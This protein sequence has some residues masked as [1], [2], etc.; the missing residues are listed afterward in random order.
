SVQLQAAA[1]AD[2]VAG[3]QVAGDTNPRFQIDSNGKM[4]W[5]T[6]TA[7][8][9]T[10]LSRTTPGSLTMNSLR[11]SNFGSAGNILNV[12]NTDSTSP[13]APNVQFIGHNAGDQELG[14]SVQN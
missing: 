13:T 7:A 5:G 10:T 1:A 11:L 4:Q 12:Q 2:L 14:I 3:V 6:G 8:L 9:D